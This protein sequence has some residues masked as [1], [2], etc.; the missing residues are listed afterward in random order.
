MSYD[1]FESFKS[2][3]DRHSLWNS[4]EA[5][6][7]AV[8]GG[9][10]SICLLD[11][12]ASLRERE[13]FPLYVAHVNHGL[14]GD[15]SDADEGFVAA[16]AK[17]LGVPFYVKKLGP[18]ELRSSP[19]G[20]EAAARKARFEFLT[21]IATQTGSS[22]IAL[23]HT[24]DDQAETFLLRLLRGSGRRGL[25]GMHPRTEEVF[26][27]PLLEISRPAVRSHLQARG[28]L[29]R[30]DSSNEDLGRTRNRVRHRLLPMLKEE[31]NPE[32]ALGLARTASVFREE[33]D[34]LDL[35][36]RDL[37]RRLL[38][39]EEQGLSVGIPALR[40]L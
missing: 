20:L 4:G 36:T 33:N 8:S 19:K 34:Y 13:A 23:G 30:E 1:L 14:R 26:I 24:R 10:D 32:I 39:V 21:G 7:I 37:E 17:R 25:G 2:T 6:L 31:F 9:A 38:R 22:R 12:F 29:W 28:I 40:M 15:E 35:V 11:L 3:L 16:S 5:V 18:D 27:R